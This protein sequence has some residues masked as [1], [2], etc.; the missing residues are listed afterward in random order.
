ATCPGDHVE[1]LLAR[2]VMDA[3]DGGSYNV[4]AGM[5]QRLPETR[6][7]LLVPEL[8]V[9]RWRVYTNELLRSTLILVKGGDPSMTHDPLQ[10]TNPGADP[11][12]SPFEDLLPQEPTLH[13]F[14]AEPLQHPDPVIG[15]PD[16][17]SGLFPG[18]Q[19]YADT[20]A[21][22]SQEFLIEQFTG[23]DLPED[24]YV[25]ESRDHGWYTPGDGTK[26]QDV[27]N[28]LELHG[29]PVNRYEHANIFH[30]SHELAQGHKVIIGVDSEDLWH[31]HPILDHLKD[32]IG[33][34]HHADHAVVISGIDTSNPADVRVIVSD[35][36]T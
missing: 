21:I 11:W 32:M 19:S 18:Q 22:R 12:I 5:A 15:T 28:L 13:P 10:P 14:G 4:R 16:Q 17:D 3:S 24:V 35:P 2:A 25:Q 36:G 6:A 29:I 7:S 27:G 33:M 8:R 26:F 9:L 1:Q 31:Q 20:C 30:L 34:Q 23:V